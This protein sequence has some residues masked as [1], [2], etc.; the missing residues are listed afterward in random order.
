L[1]PPGR[2]GR[3]YS[4]FEFSA[5]LAPGG[6]LEADAVF[7]DLQ[8]S[9]LAFGWALGLMQDGVPLFVV[10]APEPLV[11]EALVDLVRERLEGRQWFFVADRSAFAKPGGSS[12]TM[13]LEVEVLQ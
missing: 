3:T 1:E 7:T 2:H 10:E 6:P 11:N 13:T 12:A 4:H 9:A 5:R 8:R